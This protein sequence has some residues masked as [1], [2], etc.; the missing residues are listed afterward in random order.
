MTGAAGT[1]GNYAVALAEAAGLRVVAND[2]T[3]RG[4]QTPVRGEVRAGD[5]RD[6]EVIER[7]VQGVDAIIHTAALLDVGAPVDALR[8]MNTH[9][10][11][12]LCEAGRRAGVRRFV[13][14]STAMLYREGQSGPLGED[15]DIAPR[16]AYGMSKLDAEEVLHAGEGDGLRWTILRAAPLYGRRGRHFAAAL[17]A[18]GPVMRL[19]T[20]VLPR[21]VG[22]PVATLVHAEDVARACV[23]VLPRADT[24][25]GV[26]NV[27]DEDAMTLGDRVTETLRAYGLPT[28]PAGR[29]PSGILDRLARLLTVRPAGRAVDGAVLAAWR[30]VVLRHGLKPALRVRLDREALTLLHDDLVVD[31][32]KLRSLGWLPRYPRFAEGWRQVLRWYQAERWVPR[33]A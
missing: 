1:V 25:G 29:L 12:R 20:P 18:V 21:P 11:A 4:V 9:V 6:P 31:A 8:D 10:V 17:L 19:V 30:L 24:V 22:G 28:I 16:G 3:P 32:S 23:F 2:L 5:L 7:V 26:F 15:A 14:V 27:A 33:Y 13:H